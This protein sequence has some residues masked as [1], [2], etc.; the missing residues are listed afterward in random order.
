MRQGGVKGGAMRYLFGH[1]VLDTQCQELH[2]A[3]EP[4]KLRRKVFQ[5]LAYLLAHRERV[6]PKHELLAHLWPE[7]FVGD[8]ALKS[9]IKILRQALGERGRAP[10]FVRTLHGQGYR[11]VAAVEERHGEAS[12]VKSPAAPATPDPAEELPRDRTDAG[13]PSAPAQSEQPYVPPSEQ[14]TP[15]GEWPDGLGAPEAERRHLTVLVCRLVGMP[16]RAT[17]LDPEALLEV[18]P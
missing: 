9:C 8:E 13:F 16:D 1:Y 10:H 2:H 11:F 14:V 5:V 12:D 17:P 18:V 3:G 4:I 15:S 6:V 7:Q